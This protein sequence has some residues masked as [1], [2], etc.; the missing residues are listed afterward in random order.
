VSTSTLLVVTWV[1][2]TL[3]PGMNGATPVQEAAGCQSPAA[4][5][6]TNLPPVI[7]VHADGVE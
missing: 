3:V 5:S 4:T 7:L 2:Q 6:G 1:S